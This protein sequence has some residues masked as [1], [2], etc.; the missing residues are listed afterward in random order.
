MALQG[1]PRRLRAPIEGF[2]LDSTVF[3]GVR[4][5][6]MCRRHVLFDT[7]VSFP[8][9]RRIVGVFG[10]PPALLDDKFVVRRRPADSTPAS[11][12]LLADC[13]STARRPPAGRTP[14]RRRLADLSAPCRLLVGF[15]PTIRRLFAGSHALRRR[16][17]DIPPAPRR[18]IFV[19]PT[20]RRLLADSSPTLRRLLADFPPASRRLYFLLG[21]R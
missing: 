6:W 16:P 4:R 12:R 17:A 19:T 21:R 15:V 13:A 20:A 9:R 3:I 8:R 10:V 14:P 2:M 5:V 18:L 1:I 11:C 7:A